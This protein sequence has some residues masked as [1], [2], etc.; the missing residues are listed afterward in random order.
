[1]INKAL[2]A[3]LFV[4]ISSALFSQTSY[5]Q[6][7]YRRLRTLETT[8]TTDPAPSN[9]RTKL[10]SSAVDVQ[11]KS[12]KFLE[13][14]NFVYFTSSKMTSK[15]HLFYE[16]FA[17][18]KAKTNQTIHIAKIDTVPYHKQICK[19]CLDNL[20]YRFGKRKRHSTGNNFFYHQSDFV[21]TKRDYLS[22]SIP[23][24]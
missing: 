6:N 3:I 18:R 13:S 4:S 20:H 9:L 7:K 1:M 15:A 14:L 23:S 19:N 16:C 24:N 12:P 5:A 21:G 22:D 17:L 10:Y 8:K 2:P 11:L